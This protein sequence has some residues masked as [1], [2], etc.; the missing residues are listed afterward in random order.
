MPRARRARRRLSGPRGG[1]GGAGSRHGAAPGGVGASA[2]QDANDH[3]IAVVP[4]A[5]PEVA[6][7]SGGATGAG[8]RLW[9]AAR[10]GW[11]HAHR[12]FL[13]FP[14]WAGSLRAGSGRARRC[15]AL[16][17]RPMH[18][19][20]QRRS[21]E[22]PQ[23]ERGALGNSL[24]SAIGVVTGQPEAHFREEVCWF[25]GWCPA[26]LVRGEDVVEL[27][28]RRPE[29]FEIDST[30]RWLRSLRAEQVWAMAAVEA[31]RAD[32]GDAG[33][34]RPGG[35]VL[36]SPARRH[37]LANARSLEW[38]GRMRASRLRRRFAGGGAGVREPSAPGGDP[39]RATIRRCGV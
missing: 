1:R 37:A 12:S 34:L 35:R 14:G 32:P 10:T 36:G 15:R 18:R 30:G 11:V 8:A 38:L 21:A 19:A 28:R 4:R 25:Q 5:W 22:V 13:R 17:G 39:K 23:R 2:A 24:S 29:A 31:Y 20:V 3:A 7:A 26:H 6:R 33:A 16:S 27:A 9:R